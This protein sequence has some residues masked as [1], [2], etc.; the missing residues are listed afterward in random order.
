VT[1]RPFD[2]LGRDGLFLPPQAPARP[3][4][5]S[6]G[7]AALFSTPPRRKGDALIECA[8]CGAHTPVP[9]LELPLRLLPS[10]FLPF[11]RHPHLMRCPG[12]R[13]VTWCKV[14]WSGG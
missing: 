6:R 10:A 9:R 5:R 14:D 8:S 7:R 13:S 2:P 1:R 4:A 3:V 12:C 11:R